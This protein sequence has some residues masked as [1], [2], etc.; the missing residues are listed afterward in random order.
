MNKMADELNKN[1]RFRSEPRSTLS[2]YALRLKPGQEI[3]ECLLNYAKAKNLEAP[4]VLSCVGSVTQATLRL[5]NA[6][7]DTPNEIIEVEGRHEIVS[8]VGTLADEGHLHASLSDKD[9]H[10]VGGHVMGNMKVFTTAE[11][12]IGNCDML[13]FTREID[14]ETGF[15]ELVVKEK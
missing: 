5:A 8:L 1:K 11:V 2:C 3:R 12:V 10:V 9:G 4:F 7:R 6:S 15:D 14:D 13:S